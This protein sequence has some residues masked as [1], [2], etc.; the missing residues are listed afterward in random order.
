M[1][2]KGKVRW[3]EECC[4]RL[5]K[6]AAEL[7]SAIKSAELAAIRITMYGQE[8]EA[9]TQEWA[10]TPVISEIK[11]SETRTINASSAL[12]RGPCDTKRVLRR[13][14]RAIFTMGPIPKALQFK[15]ARKK[16]SK[17]QQQHTATLTTSTASIS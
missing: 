7:R 11:L 3:R 1:E 4:H 10:D 15:G 14:K 17:A 6:C 8:P 9:E 16:R 2:G 13:V 5:V 12:L